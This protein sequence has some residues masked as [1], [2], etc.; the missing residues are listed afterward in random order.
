M[1]KTFRITQ[2]IQPWEIDDLTRQIEQH[3]KVFIIS[4]KIMKLFLI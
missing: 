3:I 1:I 4:L 2:Y